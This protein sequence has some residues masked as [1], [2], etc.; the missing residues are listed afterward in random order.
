MGIESRKIQV[1]ENPQ[2]FCPNQL[3]FMFN[4]SCFFS[5]H[6]NQ[7]HGYRR[8]L[9]SEISESHESTGLF[10]L[11]AGRPQRYTMLVNRFR[12]QLY[13]IHVIQIHCIPFSDISI[14]TCSQFLGLLNIFIYIY[15]QVYKKLYVCWRPLDSTT[16]RFLAYRS[17]LLLAK[18]P[19]IF[20]IYMKWV[21]P[22]SPWKSE[23]Q[24]FPDHVLFV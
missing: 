19:Q 6:D 23:R 17:P 3:M 9:N 4:V 24:H 13:K 18:N 21:N 16:S 22:N 2:L 10:S 8:W 14:H 11:I 5:M 15:L 7:F 20:P 12:F 1:N